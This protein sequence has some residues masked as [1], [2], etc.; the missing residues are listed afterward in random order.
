M[1]PD[2]LVGS[3]AAACEGVFAG[4]DRTDMVADRGNG[5]SPN[6]QLRPQLTSVDGGAS[7]GP[8]PAWDIEATGGFAFP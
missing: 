2:Q 6:D 5:S 8:L 3:S 1:L 7:T 4:L